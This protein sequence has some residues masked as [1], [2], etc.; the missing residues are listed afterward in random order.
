MPNTYKLNG[1]YFTTYESSGR[2]AEQ[3]NYYVL[4][5]DRDGPH[6][7]PI[8]VRKATNDD[9]LVANCPGLSRF[10]VAIGD[11]IENAAR[12]LLDI[13]YDDIN[14]SYYHGVQLAMIA[15]GDALISK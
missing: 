4:V 15:S 5:T 1:L 2:P 14:K 12:K 11:T 8:T 6:I 3:H 13:L 7:Y 10:D 9:A